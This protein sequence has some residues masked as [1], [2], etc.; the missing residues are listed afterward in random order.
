M[1]N[2]RNCDSYINIPPSQTYTTDYW[3]FGLKL[4]RIVEVPLYLF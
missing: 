1:D 2:A 3:E 4:G